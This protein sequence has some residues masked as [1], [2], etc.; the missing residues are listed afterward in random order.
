MFCEH[1]STKL[2]GFKFTNNSIK[3]LKFVYTQLNDQTVLFQTIQFSISQSEMLSNIANSSIKHQSFI[4]AQLNDQT[5][6]F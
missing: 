3:H 5:V 4:Y 1:K 2:N 6:L